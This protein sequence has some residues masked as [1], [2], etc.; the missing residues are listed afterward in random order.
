[1]LTETEVVVKAISHRGFSIF[2]QEVYCF[3]GL[4]H[5]N[6]T[7]LF[8]VIANQNKLYFFLEHVSGGDLIDYLE[9]YG[10]MT[11]RMPEPCSSR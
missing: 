3:K 6:I 8:E 9:N 1:M 2:F 5:L 7:K 10:P 4:N 11:R